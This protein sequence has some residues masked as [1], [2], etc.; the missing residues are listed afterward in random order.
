MGCC[1]RCSPGMPAPGPLVASDSAPAHKCRHK[2]HIFT[3]VRIMNNN[4]S[5]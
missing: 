4:Q 5:N 3:I 1:A 2:K